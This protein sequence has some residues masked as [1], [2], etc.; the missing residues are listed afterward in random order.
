MRLLPI[1]PDAADKIWMNIISGWLH[2]SSAVQHTI[3][4][5]LSPQGKILFKQSHLYKSHRTCQHME[6]LNVEALT[7]GVNNG[8]SC[9]Q[10]LLFLYIIVLNI[11]RCNFMCLLHDATPCNISLSFRPTLSVMMLDL[12]RMFFIYTVAACLALSLWV[13]WLHLVLCSH[14][15]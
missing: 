7:H 12:S 1:N 15:Q 5:S 9:S 2:V 11:I 14:I 3:S 4:N 6:W 8:G 13:S 10:Y